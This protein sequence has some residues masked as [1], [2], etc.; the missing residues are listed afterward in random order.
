MCLEV[1]S[2]QVN[3]ELIHRRVTSGENQSSMLETRVLRK[4]HTLCHVEV[5]YH[6]L[7]DLKLLHVLTKGLLDELMFLFISKQL[8]SIERKINVS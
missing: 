3:M 2:W 1:T 4:P 6:T 5:F 8:S 7:I